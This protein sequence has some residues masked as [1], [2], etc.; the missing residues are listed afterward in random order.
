MIICSY[1]ALPQAQ[2][3]GA[4]GSEVLKAEAQVIEATAAG[5]LAPPNITFTEQNLM[6]WTRND[7]RRFLHVVYRVGDLD[8][9]I[10]YAIQFR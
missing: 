8:K 2:L 6:D 5:K 10:K 1:L 3:F 7:K 9:T 4:K